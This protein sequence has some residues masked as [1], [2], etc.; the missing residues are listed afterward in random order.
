MSGLR[1]LGASCCLVLLAVPLAGD[2]QA[3]V[4]PPPPP[5]TAA[6]AVVPPGPVPAPVVE[7]GTGTL[8]V[9]AGT[10]ARSGDG[11]LHRYRVEVETGLG[12][13]AA[14]TARVVE[15]VL[16]DDRSWGA[17]GRR[18]FQR[19]DDGS[20]DLRVLVASPDLTDQLCAPLDT[21]GE[22]SCGLDDRAVLNAR[23]W[24]T[25]AASYG[26][27]LDGYRTYLVNHEVGHVLGRSHVDCPAAGAPAPVMM[28]QTLG[29]GACRPSPW[30]F[31]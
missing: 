27:D 28:Q 9:V 11:P 23:R 22:V 8:Q 16:A 17:D 20:A 24:L 7:R 4:V 30:P 5:R 15:A 10:S 29:L 2:V 19:V 25:G 14:A 3:P 31:P 26:D 21:G 6:V 12:L 13:D 1:A 18:S